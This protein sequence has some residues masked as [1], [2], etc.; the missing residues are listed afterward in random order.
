MRSV[1]TITLG[2]VLLLTGCA[3]S[4]QGA[5]TQALPDAAPKTP[6]A[7]PSRL[8]DYSGYSYTGAC[9][10]L[11]GGDCLG[12]LDA[13]T[14]RTSVFEPAIEYTVPDDTWANMEDLPGNFLLFR[15]QDAQDGLDGGSYIGVYQNIRVPDMGCAEKWEEGVGHTPEQMIAFYRGVPG[16]DVSP[17]REVTVGGLTGY[18][19]DFE[20]KAKDTLCG[21]GGFRA[22]PLI[23][24]GGVSDL[25][26]VVAPRVDVRLILLS[27]HKGNVTIEVTNVETQYTARKWRAI[28]Q[29]IIASFQFN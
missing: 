5:N 27:W 29:P 20:V 15:P 4:S 10:N 24:G 2:A 23:I 21:F 14:Y 8:P 28:V 11:H 16:L 3:G 9:P 13:G 18:Q 1:T 22:T 25:H 12:V 26:H 17:A 19:L 7:E 6:A